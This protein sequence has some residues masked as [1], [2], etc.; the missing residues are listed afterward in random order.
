MSAFESI[1]LRHKSRIQ[2]MLVGAAVGDAA[3][4]PIEW[5]YDLTLLQD[6][7]GESTPEF[8]KESHNPFFFMPTGSNTCY[9]HQCSVVGDSL[10]KSRGFDSNDIQ[11][12][13]FNAFGPDSVYELERLVK[14]INGPWR[15]FCIAHF[16]QRYREGFRHPRT[17]TPN[18]FQSDCFFRI[19][20]VAAVY[21]GQSCY[22]DVV[23]DIITMVQSSEESRAFGLAFA[24][25]IQNLIICDDR[26]DIR[27]SVEVLMTILSDS[28]RSHRTLNDGDVVASLVLTLENI[29]TPYIEF[30]QLVGRGCGAHMCLP[31][32]IHTLINHGFDVQSA[33]RS[34]LGGGGDVV[35]RCAVVAGIIGC[36]AGFEALPEDWIEQTAHAEKVKEL[37]T[38]LAELRAEIVSS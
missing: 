27:S 26:V 20:P 24:L 22:L 15:N 16:C 2:G 38:C 3:A 14:P 18:D 5:I 21:A 34:V 19:L 36:C 23:E 6:A 35:S 1:T 11:E 13:I 32:V 29:S 12:R 25:L 17:G 30:Q 8:L 33:V 31:G 7:I 9:F 10:V 37:A 4:Q 28:S